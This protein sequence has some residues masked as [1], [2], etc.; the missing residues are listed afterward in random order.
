MVL[1]QFGCKIKSVG[2]DNTMEFHMLDFYSSNGIVHQ[3]SCVYTPQQNSVVER[4][5]QHLLSIA[6]AIHF[7]SNIP[8]QF[9]GDC[10]LIA[11]YLINRLPSPLLHNKTPYELFFKQPPSYNHLRV[12][13][14]E[15][16]AST[17]AQ[18]STKFSPR[19]R[20][21]VFLGYPFNVKGYNLFDLQSHS[22]LISRDIVFHESVF[23][24]QIDSCSSFLD[25]SIPLPCFPSASSDIVDPTLPSS[26]LSSAP[27]S[28]NPIDDSFVQVHIDLDDDF[29]QDVPNEPPEPLTDPIPLRRFARVHKQPSYLQAYHCNQVSSIPTTV[30]LHSGTSHPLSSHLSYHTLSPSYKH[31]CCSISSVVEPTYYY[32]VIFDPKWQEAIAAKIPALEANYTWTLTPLPANKKPIGCKWVYRIK[33]KSD[34]SIERYKAWLVAKEFTQN[35]GVDYNETFSPIAK[36]VSVKCLLVVAAV[37]GWY[38]GQLNVNN[39]FLHEDFSEEVYM[40]LPP[41]F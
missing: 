28:S 33:Y 8:I 29:L 32:Q 27:L 2:T 10:I 31:F 34:G 30:A 12:F 11:A 36:M 6:K 14:C 18:T 20:R 40:S 35:E 39:A 41:R 38:L 26:T 9:W 23:P 19:A 13:G 5:H 21:C 24:Y 4:K 15:C 1:T 25:H 17:V 7:Q 3:H 16:Y 37:K 22:M